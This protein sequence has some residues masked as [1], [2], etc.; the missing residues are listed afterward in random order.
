LAQTA[1]HVVFVPESY[2]ETLA[3][4]PHFVNAQDPTTGKT[5]KNELAFELPENR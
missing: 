5:T 1:H 3:P 2:G 4:N